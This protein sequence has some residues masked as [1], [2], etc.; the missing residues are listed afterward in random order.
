MS[1]ARILT[2]L[3]WNEWKQ[4]GITPRLSWIE[5]NHLA[6]Y[7][8]EQAKQKGFDYQAIDF[9]S[10]IDSGINYRENLK[11][12]EDAVNASLSGR[13]V[14]DLA[15]MYP[16]MT[17]TE[18]DGKITDL[19]I[20]LANLKQRLKR[21]KE[22]ARLDV[23]SAEASRKVAEEKA[24]KLKFAPI[25]TVKITRYIP[26]FIGADNKSYGPL[27][28]EQVVELPEASAN[29]LI[30]QGAAQPYVKPAAKDALRQEA[31]NLWTQYANAIVNNET[32]VATDILTRLKTLR[33]Q[34]TA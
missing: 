16:T 33:P 8:V 12:L 3:V 23:L 25:L 5:L 2:D 32:E 27:Y 28:P 14:E 31:E 19:E 9:Q 6:T 26:A 1:E 34:V 17:E 20:Q 30:K 22:K 29:Y 24:E 15:A 21:Q 4:R 11:A 10:I 7:L 18:K 13:A